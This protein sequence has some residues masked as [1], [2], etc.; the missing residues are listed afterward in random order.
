M[1]SA[2]LIAACLLISC[3][4]GCTINSPLVAPSTPVICGPCGAQAMAAPAITPSSGPIPE[5]PGISIPRLRDNTR[6][7]FAA[8]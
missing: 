2:I 5:A 1:R 4:A 7:M 8:Q 6:S 3:N